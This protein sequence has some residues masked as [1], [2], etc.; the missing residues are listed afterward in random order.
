[1]ARAD[2]VTPG[3][4]ILLAADG[5][6]IDGGI[7][8]VSRC[9]ARALEERSECDAV[10][11]VDRVLLHEDPRTPYPPPHRGVQK[12]ACRS[13]TRYVAQ[14]WN[15]YLRYRH[16]LILFDQV[17][18]A[19]SLPFPRLLSRR[20]RYSVFIHGIELDRA[21]KG[22]YRRALEGA[23]SVLSNSEAT[24]RKFARLFPGLE[25]KVAVTPLCIDPEK[26]ELWSR[27][28]RPPDDPDRA[29]AVLAVGRMWAEERGKGHDALLES[30]GAV[31]RR[32]PDAEL[33]MVG[34]GDDRPRLMRKAEELGVADSVRFLGYASDEQ[35]GS[36]Y[37]RAALFALPSRQEGFGLVYAEAMWHGI[38]CIAARS[39]APQEV[40]SAGETGVFVPF[41][42]AAAIAGALGELLSDS[43]R[44][45]AMGRA[46]RQRADE[47]FVFD[48]FKRVLLANLQ[49]GA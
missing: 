18:L 46:G 27:L 4:A 38:P 41:G 36:L 32:V 17:G 26:T 30:W 35:V 9:I 47:L 44:R 34:E 7:A 31:R 42:D 11:R 19:R 15:L 3:P 22:S 40:L 10:S 39:E 33:W 23:S 12:L 24:A 48:R 45:I 49:L 16:D 13:Q 20:I 21:T 28:R 43:E 2:A 8:S 29:N 14:L 25:P 1:M 5:L 37:S 6:R